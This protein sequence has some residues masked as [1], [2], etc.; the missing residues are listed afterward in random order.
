ML[1]K[2]RENFAHLDTF[3]G[4]FYNSGPFFNTHE[5]TKKVLPKVLQNFQ[6][7]KL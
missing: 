5:M 7:A 4:H 1:R 2:K 6:G 3:S